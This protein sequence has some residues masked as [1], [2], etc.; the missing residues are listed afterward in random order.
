[1]KPSHK[2]AFGIAVVSA[3]LTVAGHIGVLEWYKADV[4][5]EEGS[6]YH[7]ADQSLTSLK[8]TNFGHADA[9]QVKVS[10]FFE[11]SIREATSSR[12]GFPFTINAGGKGIKTITGTIERMVPDQ[13][14]YIYFATDR[15]EVTTSSRSFVESVVFNGGTGRPDTPSSWGTTIELTTWVLLIVGM[16]VI[17]SFVLITQRLASMR[18]G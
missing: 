1:M 3:L 10:A 12:Q 16:S 17:P 15:Q 13:T 7:S 14:L 2:W 6:W 5:Y 9:E 4:R 18:K 11:D 8:L